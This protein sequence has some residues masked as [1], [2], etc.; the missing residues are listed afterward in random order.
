MA[1]DLKVALVVRAVDKATKPLQKIRQTMGRLSRSTGLD[2]VGRNLVAVG[3][4]MGTV[5]REAGLLA[6]KLGAGFAAV[7][8][9]LFA[10]T[11][12]FA[13]ARRQ[14]RQDGGSNRHRGR[15]IAAAPARV[16]YR[17]RAHRGGKQGVALLH[18]VHRR[19]GRWHGRG[20]SDIRGNGN[21]SQG[22]P[23]QPETD[24]HAVGRGVGRVHAAGERGEER[25]RGAIPIRA[26]RPEDAHDPFD[27]AGR[28]A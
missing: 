23:R 13:K 1:R 24:A 10:L 11:N 5:G 3:R 21:W 20:C 16:R 14:H 6:L 27:G 4:Q 12:R 15:R 26:R 22:R 2:R 25:H 28:D 17:R 18:A 7:G 9:G 19:R 8:G